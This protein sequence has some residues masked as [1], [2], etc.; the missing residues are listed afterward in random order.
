MSLPFL[1]KKN[2]GW[3]A[4]LIADCLGKDKKSEPSA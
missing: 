4:S 1:F 2:F 3:I